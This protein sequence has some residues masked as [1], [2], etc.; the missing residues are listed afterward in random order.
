MILNAESGVYSLSLD[1]LLTGFPV[2]FRAPEVRKLDLQAEVADF[3]VQGFSASCTYTI[4]RTFSV[5]NASYS[6]A[7]SDLSVVRSVC[8]LEAE[9]SDYTVA[10]SEALLLKPCNLVCV[11]DSFALTLYIEDYILEMFDAAT[12]VLRTFNAPSA[13]YTYT[14]FIAN[15]PVLASDPSEYSISGTEASVL[16]TRY[17]YPEEFS[18]TLDMYLARMSQQAQYPRPE[19]VLYDTIYGDKGQFIGTMKAVDK[20]NK[21]DVE[22]GRFVKILSNKT[23]MSL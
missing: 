5:E 11:A 6:L 20:S 23:V 22:T 2:T 3:S 9:K 18:Y 14:G 15:D 17:S 1:Y 13:E 16:A 8:V 19:F 4:P 12:L 10:G 21:F 7:G